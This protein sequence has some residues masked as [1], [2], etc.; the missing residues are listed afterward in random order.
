VKFKLDENMPCRVTPLLVG[1]GH[2]LARVA[3]QGLS[4]SNDEVVA[5]VAAEE[6]RMVITLDRRF[7]DI[8]RHPPRQHPGNWSCGCLTR[9]LP[10]WSLPSTL[11][12]SNTALK[13]WLGVLWW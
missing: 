10:W 8:R 9:V 6:G 5:H 2:E 3:G 12:W 1:Y 11:I 4:G 7:A 13:I